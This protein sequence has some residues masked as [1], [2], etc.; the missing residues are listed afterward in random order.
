MSHQRER[1]A[2]RVVEPADQ[3]LAR[4]ARR[5]RRDRPRVCG[6]GCLEERARGGGERLA[7]P[8]PKRSDGADEKG[9]LFRR[10]SAR[11]SRRE[12]SRA[13]AAP[14]ASPRPFSSFW[15]SASS[16]STPSGSALRDADQRAAALGDALQQARRNRQSARRFGHVGVAFRAI[17]AVILAKRAAASA[18]AASR[19]VRQR[20]LELGEVAGDHAERR[21]GRGSTPSARGRAGSG[22]RPRCTAPA[23]GP[24]RGARDRAAAS[25]TRWRVSLEP[26]RTTT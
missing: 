22:T 12:W 13:V 3:F 15:H 16:A 1:A 17:P 8:A 10:R 6:V 23:R 9:A 2:G 11:R 18:S 14:E 25:V 20:A 19:S 4:P 26:S 24:A 5:D 7:G 21:N